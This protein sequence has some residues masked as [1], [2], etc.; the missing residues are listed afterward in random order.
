MIVRNCLFCGKEFSVKPYRIKN[1]TGKYCSR[2]CA[3]SSPINRKLRSISKLGELNPNWVGDEVGYEGLHTW[4]KKRINKPEV[5]QECGGPPSP[6]TG[7]DLANI[8]G[9]YKRDLNDWEY[10]CRLCHMTKDGRMK[11]LVSGTKNKPT[12]NV[13]NCIDCGA[14]ISLSQ[15]KRCRHCGVTE[16]HRRRKENVLYCLWFVVRTALAH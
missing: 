1:G 16:A 3:Y 11:T 6:T 10:L 14:I 2:V 12:K 4:V 5:C 15:H 13:L 7:L 8:S 9:E